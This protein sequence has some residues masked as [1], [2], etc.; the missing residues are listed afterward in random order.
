MVYFI[1]LIGC[2]ALDWQK[3]LQQEEKKTLQ[4][5]TQLATAQLQALKMQL[6]PHF[7]FNTLQ[8][9]SEL[10][11]QDVGLADEMMVRLAD[12]LRLTLASGGT[13]EVTLE[14]ELEFLRCYLEIEQ[15]RF[16]DRLKIVFEVDQEV[17][18]AVVPNL[19]LQPIVENAIRHGISR[20]S[21]SG[22]I[23]IHAHRA[24]E[25]LQVSVKDNGAG[26][27]VSSEREQLFEKG[28]G[29]S[30]TRARL[31]RAFGSRFQL[32]LANVA[33]GGFMVTLQIPF[34]LR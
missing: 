6:Q 17:N 10:M 14:K 27:P 25:H 1:V 23:E 32:D 29:L 3:R 34:V 28:L 4:L 16:R 30:N 9:I 24:G 21:L 18:E 2:H 15:V 22:Q 11:H 12:F 5:E 19:I 13:Q 7:L 8:S 33:E 31:Q 20:S 26:L